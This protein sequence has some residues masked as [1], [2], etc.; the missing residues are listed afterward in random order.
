MDLKKIDNNGKIIMVPGTR[1]NYRCAFP[2]PLDIALNKNVSVDS[3]HFLSNN[4][5]REEIC[6]LSM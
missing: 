1:F 6:I 3:Q 2:L 4:I 5:R